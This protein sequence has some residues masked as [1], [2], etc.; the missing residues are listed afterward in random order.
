MRSFSLN[1]TVLLFWCS[2]IPSSTTF[3]TVT[4]FGRSV[5]VHKDFVVAFPCGL[6]FKTLFLVP[7]LL[8]RFKPLRCDPSSCRPREAESRTTT[9]LRALSRDNTFH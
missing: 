2:Y 3:L 5:V 8:E 9:L 4:R 1:L 6:Q 7:S